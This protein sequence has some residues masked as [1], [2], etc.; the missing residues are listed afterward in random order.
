MNLRTLL[1]LKPKADLKQLYKDGAIVVDVR[2]PQE[3]K[4]GHFGK[5]INIPLDKITS[6]ID[7]LKSK[8]KPVILICRSGARAGSAKGILK[9]NGLDEVYNGGGW[10]SFR[11]KVR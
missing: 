10:E 9:G 4:S 1:G 7:Y 6:K 3:Y 5:S 11:M 2:T 8:N